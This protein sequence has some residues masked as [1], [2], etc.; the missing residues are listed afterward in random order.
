MKNSTNEHE[1][2][3]PMILVLNKY[4]PT[5][6]F[7]QRNPHKIIASK[8]KKFIQTIWVNHFLFSNLYDAN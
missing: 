7:S 3:I 8:M 4:D 1:E 6:L 5:D 2:S